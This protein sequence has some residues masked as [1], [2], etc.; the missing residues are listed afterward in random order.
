[1]A[2]DV[3]TGEGSM[4]GGVEGLGQVKVSRG[5]VYYFTWKQSKGREK[6]IK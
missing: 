1:M 5:I 3:A 6:E 2:S 4:A